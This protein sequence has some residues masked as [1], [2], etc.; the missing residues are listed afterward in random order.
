[1][2]RF[3]E[4]VLQQA[5]FDLLRQHDLFL[6]GKAR[7]VHVY[8]QTPNCWRVFYYHRGEECQA[9]G[10]FT[11]TAASGVFLLTWAI[12]PTSNERVEYHTEHL[13]P[14]KQATRAL[15][16]VIAEHA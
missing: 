6:D 13:Y 15:H 3:E 8:K 16:G 9:A 11:G 12:T 1:M 10:T 14:L 7:F 5:F 4:M 2:T